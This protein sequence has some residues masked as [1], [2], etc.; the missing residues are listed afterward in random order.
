MKRSQLCS[1]ELSWQKNNLDLVSH[2]SCQLVLKLVWTSLPPLNYKGNFKKN[3]RPGFFR[4]VL[5]KLFI[6]YFDSCLVKK[7]F[8]SILLPNFSPFKP[9]IFKFE[10]KVL[11]VRGCIVFIKRSDRLWVISVVIAQWWWMATQIVNDA[12]FIQCVFFTKYLSFI[13]F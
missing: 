4:K 7:I 10:T 5:V 6:F 11:N 2:A 1:R 3:Y 12:S 9:A 8:W 13:C